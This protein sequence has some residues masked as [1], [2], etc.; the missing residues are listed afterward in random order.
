[1][2][3]TF[4]PS[5]TARAAYFMIREI[6]CYVAHVTELRDKLLSL[7]IGE[8]TIETARKLAGVRTFQRGPTDWYAYLSECITEDRARAIVDALIING[9]ITYNYVSAQT[10]KPT[11]AIYCEDRIVT[12]L[13]DDIDH[14]LRGG[15]SDL[16]AKNP[17]PEAEKPCNIR[18]DDS[19]WVPLSR[20]LVMVGVNPNQH[21]WQITAK[22]S[23]SKALALGLTPPT[24]K[25]ARGGVA[26]KHLPIIVH[27]IC[28]QVGL[29]PKDS[30]FSLKTAEENLTESDAEWFRGER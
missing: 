18:P 6:G 15:R 1:M 2:S 28:K 14:V 21:T 27:E 10:T 7:G 17:E 3:D 5:K 16:P 29:L 9:L 8:C 12:A 20:A 4:K 13:F 24:Y 30:H 25:N 23:I 19:D 22:P 11:R 26:R